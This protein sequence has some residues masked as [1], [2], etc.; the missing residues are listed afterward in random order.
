LSKIVEVASK[1]RIVL[2]RFRRMNLRRE[3]SANRNEIIAK[4]CCMINISPTK[5]DAGTA[6]A[7]PKLPMRSSFFE[8]L[9]SG[10]KWDQRV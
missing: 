5:N 4:K 7:S 1:I 10:S 3:Q 9:G 6:T 2:P 8:I